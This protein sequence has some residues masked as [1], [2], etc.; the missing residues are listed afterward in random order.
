MCHDKSLM[1]NFKSIPE[2]SWEI[3]VIG[4]V[5]IYAL[6]QGDIHVVTTVDGATQARVLNNVLYVPDLGTNLLSIAS[7]TDRGL[8]VE[9]LKQTVLFKSNGTTILSGHRRGKALY[10][11]NI[12]ATAISSLETQSTALQAFVKKVPL[13]TWHQRLSHRSYSTVIRMMKAG[14]VN[15]MDFEDSQPPTTLCPGCSLGKAHRLPFTSVR[16]K[17]TELGELI[18]C[19]PMQVESPLGSKYYVTFKDDYSGYREIYILKKKS[20]VFEKFKLFICKIRSETK[21]LVRTLRSD[22]GGELTSS[23]FET[24]MTSKNIRHETSQAHTPQLNSVSERDH[25]TIGE[26]ERSC[27]H[28]QNVPL[29]LWAESYNCAAYTLN[30]TPSTDSHVTPY[31][32][33]FK[34]KPHLGHLRIFGCTA[35]VHVP[36][37]D[38][39]KLDAKSTRCMF[40]GY[41]DTTKAYRLWDPAT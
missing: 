29:D 7:A 2:L 6:G 24:W 27:I 10:K 30:R 3:N 22:G 16:T 39:K 14:I 25:R 11:F 33:W 40:I 8:N 31:E 36:D 1:H 17:A 9:F 4:G 32:L 23:E 41:C 18:V 20:E 28:M 15:G 37:C 5:T 12:S 19:G 26:A 13:S 35:Y 21:A 34:K 38:R